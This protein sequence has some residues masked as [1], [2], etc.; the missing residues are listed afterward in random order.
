MA[1]GSLRVR[2][3]SG[4][5]FSINAP[6]GS[7]KRERGIR[8]LAFD[9]ATLGND[10]VLVTHAQSVPGWPQCVQWRRRKNLKPRTSGR[11][12]GRAARGIRFEAL[13]SKRHPGR[14]GLPEEG[15]FGG[16]ESV[17]FVDEVADLAFQDE[18][19]GGEGAGGF[20]SSGVLFAEVLER[21]G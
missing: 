10:D 16:C 15:D 14:G 1:A 21:G 13:C 2:R 5:L 9:F 18:G 4:G 12:D 11:L 3:G 20:D 19:F 7:S 6:R 8:S 17:G